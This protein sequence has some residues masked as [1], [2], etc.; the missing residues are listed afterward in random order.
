MRIPTIFCFLLLCAQSFAQNN[1]NVYP[2]HWFAGMKDSKLQLVIRSQTD[3]PKSVSINYPG[4]RVIETVQPENKH[5]LFVYLQLSA[6]VKPG[7]VQIKIGSERITYQIRARRPTTGKHA[8]GV[9]SKDFIYL[10]MPDRFS[11]GDPSNDKFRDLRDT[12]S[13]RKNPFLR[14]GGDFKGIANHFD[15]FSELGVTT[16]WLMPVIEN[17]MPQMS[18]WNNSVA[19][20]HGYWFTD[21]YQ[22][23][24][25]LGGNEGYKE[26]VEQAHSKGLKIIQD[27]VYNH[28][29]SHHWIA[30][31]P[32]QKEWL[33]NWPVY[34]APNH[35]EEAIMDPWASKTDRKIMLEG[36]FV[37]HL[38][39]LNLANRHLARYMLQH[40][41][42]T[43]EEFGIDGWRVDTYKYCDEKFLNDVNSAL[44]KEFP[45]ITVFGEAWTNSTVAS[46][47]F[48]KNNLQVPFKH[49]AHGVTD[50]P[51]AAAMQSAVNQAPA[52]TD[53]LNKLYMTLSQDLLYKDPL[54]NCTFLDNHDMDRIFSVVGEDIGKLKTAVG[55]LMTVRGIPQLYYGTEI[56][57]K[58][59]KNPSDA[60][61]RRDFPGG[62]EG[63]PEN[64][65]TQA[66]RSKTENEMFEF[67]RTLANY[68][69]NSTA[70]TTGRTMQFI[71]DKGVYVYFRYD[72]RSSVMCIVNQSDAD[73][74]VDMDRYAERLNGFTKFRNI[75]TDS[76]STL[77]NVRVPGKSFTVYELQR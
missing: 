9:T 40:A 3:L 63:D 61:V 48:T 72:A 62:W 32:P 4:I 44:V 57:M 22:V 66:G 64:K 14:H 69:K 17:D 71:P 7:E 34:Q 58:N 49:N 43:T 74:D 65:F 56:L 50:F 16:L 59:F 1:L 21:H 41:V 77:S 39:D 19:G 28:I 67:V 12:A 36:W 23:D 25:R 53:G 75:L 52:W 26:F 20:Y 2:T 35:R 55:L 5:Y 30:L 6:A 38:P 68:R 76:T 60:E 33:N 29:G 47:Y 13:D 27:A 8:Q 73:T 42:W 15:Y 46:A 70:L 45:S 31:D 18:E 51:L 54:Q 37:P 24:K 11:N 10:L